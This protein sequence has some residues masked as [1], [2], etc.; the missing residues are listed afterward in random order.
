MVKQ[1]HSGTRQSHSTKDLPSYY[2]YVMIIIYIIHFYYYMM[3]IILILVDIYWYGMIPRSGIVRDPGR[4]NQ[5]LPP[6]LQDALRHH[7]TQASILDN[8]DE[9]L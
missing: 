7:Q 9:N 8:S 5:G 3:I 2:Y 4:N 6:P 1:E